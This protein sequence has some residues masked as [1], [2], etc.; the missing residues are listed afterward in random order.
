MLKE[1]RNSIFRVW[2]CLEKSV[3][4]WGTA[5]ALQAHQLDNVT[6][7]K[8]PSTFSFTQ[9]CWGVMFWI[10]LCPPRKICP[11]PQYLKM[12]PY[13]KIES[14][15]KMR[16]YWSRV[17]PLNP[18]WVIALKKRKTQK[19]DGPVRT[20]RHRESTSEDGGRRCSDASI[21]QGTPGVYQPRPEAKEKRG[22][23]SACEPLEGASPADT[24]ISGF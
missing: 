11:G 1:K 10:E 22:P 2:F 6:D 15:V 4:L 18:T 23:D 17:G 3:A 7:K 9:F 16:S 24:S 8:W 13:L 19:Q 14:L 5:V 12:W 21:S 20:Q